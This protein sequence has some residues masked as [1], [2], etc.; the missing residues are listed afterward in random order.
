MPVDVKG[1]IS[2]KLGVYG[3]GANES[4]QER[5]LGVTT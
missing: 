5:E 2:S 4:G 1:E 3:S